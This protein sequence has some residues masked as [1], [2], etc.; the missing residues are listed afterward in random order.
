MCCFNSNRNMVGKIWFKGNNRISRNKDKIENGNKGRD[1]DENRGNIA[2][3]A[4]V[5]NFPQWPASSQ[6][7][8]KRRMHRTSGMCPT[9]RAHSQVSQIGEQKGE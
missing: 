9:H 4:C 5:E 7:I 1:K 6:C 3:Q 2:T 8:W